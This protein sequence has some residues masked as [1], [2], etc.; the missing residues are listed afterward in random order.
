MNKHRHVSQQYLPPHLPPSTTLATSYR[1]VSPKSSCSNLPAVIGIF[2]L[3]RT[4]SHHAIA[5]RTEM[6]QFSAPHVAVWTQTDLPPP[7]DDGEVHTSRIAAVI[8]V[9]C[10]P[11]A[12]GEKL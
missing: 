12:R 9:P 10:T 4:P 1:T 8:R 6:D 11:Y 3:E 5:D 7:L 2:S